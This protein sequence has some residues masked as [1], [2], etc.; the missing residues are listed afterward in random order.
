MSHIR[1]YLTLQEQMRLPAAL[2][3]VQLHLSPDELVS[4]LEWRE[5][6]DLALVTLGGFSS[7]RQ[8]PC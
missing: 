8:S 3:V 5:P 1:G 4:M 2:V 6:I 7:K